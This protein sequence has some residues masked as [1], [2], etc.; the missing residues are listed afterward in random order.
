[1]RAEF[2][3][4][5]LIIIVGFTV[6]DETRGCGRCKRVRNVLD[7]TKRH[8][9]NQINVGS[10]C[11]VSVTTLLINDNYLTRIPRFNNNQW[12]SLKRIIVHNNPLNCSL[13]C[14]NTDGLI[15]ESDCECDRGNIYFIKLYIFI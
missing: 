8:I 9:F 4:I 6:G 11:S 12:P 13:T 15:I 5:L 3:F 14:D 1:M 10:L 7:C 2:Y